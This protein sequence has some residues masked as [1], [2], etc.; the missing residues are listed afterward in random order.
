MEM[1]AL[2]IMPS[3]RKSFSVRDIPL[4]AV[5]TRASIFTVSTCLMLDVPALSVQQRSQCLDI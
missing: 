5:T 3:A 2:M 4:K 1:V